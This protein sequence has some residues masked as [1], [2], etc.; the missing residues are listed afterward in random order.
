MYIV[1]SMMYFCKLQGSAIQYLVLWEGWPKEASQWL[2]VENLGSALLRYKI[3]N[4][5]NILYNYTFH[6]A[7]KI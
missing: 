6:H 2:I 1:Y 7:Q 4:L 5:I 3:Y